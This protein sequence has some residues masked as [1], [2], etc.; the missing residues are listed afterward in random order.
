MRHKS[1]GIDLTARVQNSAPGV[2]ADFVR[3]VDAERMPLVNHKSKVIK[4]TAQGAKQR[5]RRSAPIAFEMSTMSTRRECTTEAK[6]WGKK[7]FRL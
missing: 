3:G 7:R 5:T 1:N 4:L 2:A 6:S